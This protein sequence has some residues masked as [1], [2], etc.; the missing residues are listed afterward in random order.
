[1]SDFGLRIRTNLLRDKARDFVF[2]ALHVHEKKMGLWEQLPV[3]NDLGLGEFINWIFPLVSPEADQFAKWFQKFVDEALATNAIKSEGIFGPVI[4]SGHG[5]LDKP[6]H[7]WANMIGE[8]A[9]S[10]FSSADDY[11]IMISGFLHYLSH[12][13]PVYERLS[14]E[15]RS[16]FSPAVARGLN[17]VFSESHN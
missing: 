4:Q 2:S 5:N 13:P 6:G 10:T 1:M 14:T 17:D 3:L 8:G 9:F 16:K 12:Y 7:N 15:V 11:G